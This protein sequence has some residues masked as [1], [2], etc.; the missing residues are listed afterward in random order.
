MFIVL[1]YRDV[2]RLLAFEA[3]TYV[4]GNLFLGGK[5]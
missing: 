3:M 4:S 2:V 1:K 5:G